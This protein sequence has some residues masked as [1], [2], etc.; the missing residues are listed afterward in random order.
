MVRSFSCLLRFLPSHYLYKLCITDITFFGRPG[1]FLK[2]SE[3]GK[4]CR[5]LR[6]FKFLFDIFHSSIWRHLFRNDLTEWLLWVS[7]GDCSLV[8]SRTVEVVILWGMRSLLSPTI[9]L[10]GPTDSETQHEWEGEHR[11]DQDIHHHGPGQAHTGPVGS[12]REDGQ[13]LQRYSLLKSLY[14]YTVHIKYILC[15]NTLDIKFVRRE[16]LPSL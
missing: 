3:E 5:F 2:G 7:A 10:L 1:K 8:W 13:E 9:S 4:V 12:W 14:R 11:Q 6:G 16:T 15:L